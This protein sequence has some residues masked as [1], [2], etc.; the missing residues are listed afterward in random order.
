MK[1][2]I[3][4]LTLLAAHSLS[5]QTIYDSPYVK[6]GKSFKLSVPSDYLRV[7]G[8]PAIGY[9]IY[10]NDKT[11]TLEDF[12]NGQESDMYM[13]GI[14]DREGVESPRA[15]F[16]EEIR[17][18]GATTVLQEPAIMATKGGDFLHAVVKVG[19]GDFSVK[20]MRVGLI[21]FED[22]MV[23]VMYT[24]PLNEK[25]E[26]S[27]SKFEKVLLSFTPYETT[28]DNQLNAVED[29]DYDFFQ[30]SEF[31][32]SVVYEDVFFEDDFEGKEFTWNEKMDED[33]EKL[34]LSY[35]YT[36][37]KDGKSVEEG[38]I[39]VFSAGD[40]K[41]YVYGASKDEAVYKVFPQHMIRRMSA[42]ET[43]EN[44]TLT[45]TKYDF[46]IGT[47]APTRVQALYSTTFKGELIFI[48]AEKTIDA[49]DQ[50]GAVCKELLMTMWFWDA[51]AYG[52]D[53]KE[54]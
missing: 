51:E 18:D 2:S 38:M 43:F 26:I 45:F 9:D 50:F 46:M 15:F 40:L 39:K 49:S 10:S 20:N 37:K 41:Q 14:I 35:S 19:E 47:K 3:L 1:F 52:E 5:A 53:P 22:K 34:L 27:S 8:G 4:F 25:D 31:E 7:G 28:R 30:N 48:L 29:E 21:V 13:F 6:D 36:S 23:M 16:N 32:T 54:E 12:G 33:V 24:P 44:E 17:T 42:S 11:K